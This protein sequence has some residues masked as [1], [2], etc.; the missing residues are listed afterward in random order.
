MGNFLVDAVYDE[1]T[2]E[3]L[4]AHPIAGGA[5]QTP[6]AD[7]AKSLPEVVRQIEEILVN[8]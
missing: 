6:P 1:A 4:T 8:F 7:A 2:I 3:K 5:V